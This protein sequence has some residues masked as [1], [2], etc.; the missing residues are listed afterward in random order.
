VLSHPSSTLQYCAQEEF[1]P[2]VSCSAIWIVPGMLAVPLPESATW[3]VKEK[4]PAVVGE[5]ATEPSLLSASP[6]GSAPETT[7][8]VYGALPPL[9]DSATAAYATPASPLWNGGLDAA[10]GAVGLGLGDGDEAA[11]TGVVAGDLATGPH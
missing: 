5:P 8:H 2:A 10:N 7:L 1:R 11:A 9:A 4:I 3:M 6:S